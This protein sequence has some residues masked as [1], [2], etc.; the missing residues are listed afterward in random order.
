MEAGDCEWPEII[1]AIGCAK[2]LRGLSP[3][4]CALKG[5]SMI[6]P[7]FL[8]RLII[9]AAVRF[10]FYSKTRYRLVTGGRQNLFGQVFRFQ[11]FGD[12]AESCRP[13]FII[14]VIQFN[15]RHE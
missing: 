6:Q 5:K 8:T 9:L 13:R 14:V 15:I 7:I 3:E 10:S 2:K 4:L 12:G 1:F 11:K